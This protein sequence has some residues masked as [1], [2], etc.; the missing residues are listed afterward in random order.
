MARPRRRNLLERQ[1]QGQDDRKWLWK[2]IRF[3]ERTDLSRCL[4][5]LLEH[6]LPGELSR[7]VRSCAEALVQLQD[8]QYGVVIAGGDKIARTAAV[9]ESAGWHWGR[10]ALEGLGFIRSI[11]RGGGRL[12]NDEKGDWRGHAN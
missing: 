11:E 7:V 1:Q 10:P 4:D 2:K 5:A 8:K 9:S 3:N 6:F 12:P